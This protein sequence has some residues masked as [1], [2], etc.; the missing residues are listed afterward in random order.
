MV[1]EERKGRLPLIIM[2]ISGSVI[3][4]LYTNKKGLKKTIET[5]RLWCIFE[6]TGRLLPYTL[7]GRA[8][9]EP[10]LVS[11]SE[12]GRWIEAVVKSSGSSGAK[13]AASAKRTTKEKTVPKVSTGRADES[14]LVLKRLI[15]IIH[16]RREEMPEGSYTAYLFKEGIPKIKKKLGEEAVEL[17]I[18]GDRDNT[19]YETAD[20]LYHLL[21]FLEAESIGLN[22]VLK[23]LKSRMDKE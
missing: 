8:G 23:E 16:R 17:L 3:D 1:I 11:I 13:A 10:K 5:D 20:L 7:P 4:L 15:E 12:K 18:S 21:V 9:E 6:E 2:D 19:I 14:A 22:E